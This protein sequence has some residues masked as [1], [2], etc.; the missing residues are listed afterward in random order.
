MLFSAAI[1]MAM[2]LLFV[3]TYVVSRLAR[4][5]AVVAD[6]LVASSANS[7]QLV[8]TQVGRWACPW[9]KAATDR[10]FKPATLLRAA[11]APQPP[12]RGALAVPGGWQAKPT[13][14]RAAEPTPPGGQPTA[15]SLDR[16]QIKSINAS[17]A[18]APLNVTR[19][20]W[21][22]NA[23]TT[24][25]ALSSERPAPPQSAWLEVPCHALRARPLGQRACRCGCSCF[26]CRRC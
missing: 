12:L 10:G 2:G 6:G 19:D 3:N 24:V 7:L 22:I 9:R 1:V 23:T 18:Q 21:Y 16:L 20:A 5:A 25:N 11:D 13:A 15:S 26:T 4:Q 17:L 14:R 8:N